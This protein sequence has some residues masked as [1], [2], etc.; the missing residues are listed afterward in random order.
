MA[1]CVRHHVVAHHGSQQGSYS[2]TTAAAQELLSKTVRRLPQCLQRGNLE[3]DR[4]QC[5]SCMKKWGIA[6]FSSINSKLMLQLPSEDKNSPS[7]LIKLNN[8]HCLSRYPCWKYCKNFLHYIYFTRQ[9]RSW[10]IYRK[11]QDKNK[12]AYIHNGS[13]NSAK[14]EQSHCTQSLIRVIFS[15]FLFLLKA[16][17]ANLS[18]QVFDAHHYHI[19]LEIGCHA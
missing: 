6:P 12:S 14:S 18:L 17:S 2:V 5:R 3:A 13:M 19:Q 1:K 4:D 9:T 15:I 11:S 16:T 8:I 7:Y 10:V